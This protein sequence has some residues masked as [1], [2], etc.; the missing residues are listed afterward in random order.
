MKTRYA[1]LAVLTAAAV[2]AILATLA[3]AAPHSG[4]AFP[5]HA[6]GR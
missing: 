6:P 5:A 1:G 2:T 4:P 3:A